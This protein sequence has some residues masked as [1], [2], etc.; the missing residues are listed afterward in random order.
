M[1]GNVV[2]CVQR[3]KPSLK[4]MAFVVSQI[5]DPKNSISEL[6]PSLSD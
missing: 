2:L 4:E 5:A 3:K 6:T 1:V